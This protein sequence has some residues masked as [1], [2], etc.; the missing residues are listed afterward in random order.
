VNV[1]L[2]HPSPDG[3][4]AEAMRRRGL[5]P[6]RALLLPLALALG[7]AAMALIDAVRQNPRLSASFI[8][9][10][11]LIAVWTLALFARATRGGRRF[12][13]SVTLRPQH[14][15]QA[16][17]HAS[18]FLYWGWHWRQVYDSS[19][20]IVAQLVFAYAIDV[21]IAWTRRDEYSLGFG[22]FPVVFSTNL[23]LWFRNDWF[24]LQFAMLGIGFAGKALITWTRDGRRVHIFNPSAF[25]LT[26]ASIA[27]LAS[28]ATDLT[29]GREIA[30]TQFY[31]PHMYLFLF[32]VALPGQ[33][34]FGVTTMTMSAVVTTYAIGLAYFAATGTYF[35]I[36]SYVPIAVFLGMHLL[37]TD[38]STS[39]R[40]EL[41]RVLFGASYGASVV[42]LYAA[43]AGLGLPTFYDKLLQVPLLNL[44]VRGIDRV[45]R[46]SFDG[47]VVFNARARVTREARP[48]LLTDRRRNL[49]WVAAWVVVFGSMSTAGGLGDE[50]RGQWLPFWRDACDAG[51]AGS[52]A[53]VTELEATL[54]RA[55]SG[56]AC[57]ELAI[58][59][60]GDDRPLAALAAW[61]RGCEL[62]FA[63]ACANA[64]RTNA[65]TVL[66]TGPPAI[67]DYAILVRGSRG[68]I[69]R[70]D[71]QWLRA[72]A[73]SIGFREACDIHP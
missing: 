23:F 60:A 17:A 50:H 28:G 56:W 30:V 51:R 7:L 19:H 6:R 69:G 4:A 34:L 61:E 45:V 1:V 5:S 41:G 26:I 58:G 70:R 32:L 37:F 43:L 40:T 8:G 72:R 71:P 14:Y 42:A 54:C 49:A 36:D 25:A 33:L 64:G 55:G 16:C 48:A 67:V 3:A 22:P 15:V 63:P 11:T 59:E 44:C 52:C 27:L 31:P 20:L 46:A 57:N 13:L 21:L 62:G 65:G 9:A 2:H 39:P 38:P 12:G 47:G 18:I 29:W 73:C 66:A 53:Y 68:P 24:F 10:S 35:F